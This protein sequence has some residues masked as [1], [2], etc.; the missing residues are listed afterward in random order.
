MKEVFEK[1]GFS[2][3]EFQCL[4]RHDGDY[5]ISVGIV[6]TGLVLTATI[7]QRASIVITEPLDAVQLEALVEKLKAAIRESLC[8]TP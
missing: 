2:V 8:A 5:S 4:C 7:L 6:E 3:D 1:A